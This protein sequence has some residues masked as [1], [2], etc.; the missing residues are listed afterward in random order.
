[1]NILCSGCFKKYNE[2]LGLCP[3]CGYEGDDSSGEIP[4]LKPGT[5]LKGRYVVGRVLGYGGFGVTYMAWDTVLEQKVAVKEYLPGEFST[6]MPG[7]TQVTVFSG[8]K[9]EQFND[10]AEKFVDEANRLA[11]FRDTDGIVQVYE[12]FRENNTAYIVMEYLDGMTLSKYLSTTGKLPAKKAIQM[13]MPAMQSLQKVHKGGIIHRD[14]APDNIMITNDGQVKLIDFGAARYAT[15]THSRSLTVVIK[16][17]YS[18]EEQ[19]RSRGDQGPWTDV[20]ALG[21]TMYRMITGVAP[22]D[23]MERRAFFEGKKKDIL[24]PVSK[25]S[26]KISSNQETALLNAMNVRI[27]D[28][29][30]DMETF[31][32]ELCSNDNVKRKTDK[33][34]KID[35][36]KWPLWMK[37]SVPVAA[38]F[39]G[40]LSVLFATGLIGFSSNLAGSYNI[41]AGMTRVP[42]LI[43]IDL[44]DAEIRSGESLLELRV[45]GKED[46]D[47]I[48]ADLI[49]SQN[50][51]PGSIVAIGT[52]L[53]IMISGGE[54]VD[55]FETDE[56]GRLFLADVS[57]RTL[58]DAVERLESQGME[59]VIIEEESDTIAAGLIISQNPDAGTP[60]EPGS[61]VTIFVSIGSS[62][63]TAIAAQEP[64]PESTPESTPEPTPE[65]PPEST[66]E[67]APEPTPESTPIPTV[68]PVPDAPLTFGS[69]RARWRPV[70]THWASSDFGPEVSD[71]FEVSFVAEIPGGWEIP[72]DNAAIIVTDS[73]G[74]TVNYM[75]KFWGSNSNGDFYVRAL[76]AAY[77]E[78]IMWGSL[79]ENA[80]QPGH[81]YTWTAFVILDGQRFEIQRQSFTFSLP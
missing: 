5:T 29:T 56:Q 7:H 43:G 4:H 80:F 72:T 33:I 17:G 57:F 55:L 71:Y 64:T 79:Y 69:L 78:F 18:P 26:V 35:I 48:P 13:L 60:L 59:V 50:L 61:R 6:R 70:N 14:I 2:E 54:D 19:Y 44:N 30:P 67:P 41:P 32:Q 66:P 45:V 42:S 22:P 51:S 40:V 23:A 74:N 12:S 1:M 81:T 11:R 36:L 65:P 53:N 68:P 58:D 3:F 76:Y 15:T 63:N 38:C 37:A 77:P 10:G 24:P 21:A 8:E 25:Y 62:T 27:E 20:Y 52:D 49:L 9:A 46:S 75:G 31:E 16:T 28:R 47:D 39:V 73:S 34:K